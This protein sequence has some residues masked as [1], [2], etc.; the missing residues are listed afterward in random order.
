MMNNPF[1]VLV[2]NSSIRTLLLIAFSLLLLL[3]LAV[4][5]VALHR[6]NT[7]TDGINQFVEQQARIEFLAQRANQYS[8]N[9]A[10]HLLLLL[11]TDERYKR[12]PLYTAMDSALAASDAAI[13][14]LERAASMGGD[15]GDIDQLINLRK[16]YGDSFQ[17]TVERIEI[18][19][20]SS[21]RQHYE[22]QTDVL[23][24]ALLVQTLR[25]AEH[26]Q[27][28]MQ[29]GVIALKDDAN[30]ARL[31][32]IILAFSAL[33]TGSVLALLIARSIAKPVHKAVMVAEAIAGGDYQ[34]KVPLGLGVETKALMRAL[35]TMRRSISTREQHIL[36][37]AYADPLTELPNRT[38]FMEALTEAALQGSGALVLID[39]DR[40][41]QINNALGHLVGDRL[42]QE[43]AQRL[44]A[45]VAGKHLVARLGG[46]EFALLI[47]EVD[48]FNIL[49]NAQELLGQL[50]KPI[51][52]DG[53]RLDVEGSLGIAI[54][55]EDGN[56]S[57]LLMRRAGMA[58]RHAKRRR[59]GFAFACKIAD[60]SPH[61]Q[62]ALIGEMRD[63][64]I[65][66]EFVAF[67]QPKLELASGL[68]KGAEALLRWQHPTKGLVPPGRFIPFAEQTGFI[69]EI[70]PWLLAH[71]ICQAASWHREGHDIVTSVNLSTLDL[72]SPDLVPKVIKS[73]QENTLPAQ[74]LC[75]EVT[76]SALMDDPDIALQ[77]L[78]ELASLGV[79]LSIDDYG[80]G[81]ASLA[82]VKNLPVHELKIDRIFV[83]G[84]DQHFR[85]A[86]IVRSTI[87]LCQEL[88]LSVVAEGA[89]TQE[90]LAWL[91]AN[92]CDTVQGYVVAK[93]MPAEEFAGWV[94]V[95]HTQNREDGIF[96]HTVELYT[97]QK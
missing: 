67:F 97:E 96:P 26:Q 64:L 34:C 79:K 83:S 38:C 9:A 56:N 19:G 91:R 50:R 61:E 24:K 49:D 70:T 11:Q 2:D 13:E 93:P 6:F 4:S 89:E 31:T 30:R 73:L 8:Q 46:D 29:S 87:L 80:S 59:D 10:L 75:L 85:N 51:E 77:H 22:E 55:P 69:R 12:V 66:E 15:V 21:A 7:L 92:H 54:F 74:L 23:L 81:Q 27:E 33:V 36:R 44:L 57:S 60:E 42:L 90:E 62:L 72:T 20:L 17:Q 48:Y 71:V 65:N 35:D 78:K 84:V 86:A 88:G 40:F 47:K 32:V 68:V 53:Q 37:L 28:L 94:T 1:L 76:E 5:S 3:L 16:H 82:Y 58:M 95:H 63:A 18:D 14:G 52:L 43:M 45:M 41:A 39:I 25:I